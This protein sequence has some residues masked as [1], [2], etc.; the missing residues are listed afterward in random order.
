[1]K[2]KLKPLAEEAASALLTTMIFIVVLALSIGGYMSYVFQ[3]ARLGG[4]S[5]AW[6]MSMAVAEA[7]LEEGFEHLN[8][9]YYIM[10][11][12]GWQSDGG[13]VYHVTRTLNGTFEATYTVTINYANTAQPTIS[14]SAYVKPPAVAQNTTRSPFFY[15]T[16]G[17]NQTPV[18][19][20]NSVTVGRGIQAVLDKPSFFNA[21]MVAKGN[22]TMDGNGVTVDSFDSGTSGQNVNGQWNQSISGND[23]IVA[24]DGGISNSIS[25]GNA[26]IY[27][28]LYV[29][30]GEPYSIG[31]NGF[32][33]THQWVAGGGTGVEPGYAHTD[34]NFD[35]PNTS[36]PNGY[37]NFTPPSSGTIATVTG[38]NII[39]ST[40]ANVASY[41]TGLTNGQ[42]L[43]A[44]LTNTTMITV[45]NGY[46]GAIPGLTSNSAF[47]TVS[48]YPGVE[49]GLV[50]NCANT[51]TTTTDPGSQP[52]LVITS[53]ITNVTTLPSPPP[54]NVTTNYKGSGHSKQISSYSYTVT[55]YSYANQ[56]T[57]T[58]KSWEYTY[59][60]NTYTYTLYSSQIT[61]A[62]SN[63]AAVLS[64]GYYVA[65]SE[66][67]GT[68]I[69]TGP[70]TL[71]MPNGYNIDNLVIAPGGS[72]VVYSGGTSLTLSGQGIIN[73]PG[74]AQNLMIYC[75]PSV[76]SIAFSGNAGLNA[77]IV[78]PNANVTLS[79]GGNNN[80]DFSGSIMANSVTLHGHWNF[81][82]D[83]ALSRVPSPGRYIL[84]SWTEV[85][86]PQRSSLPSTSE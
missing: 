86:V 34:A 18:A 20:S 32:V 58:Y 63:Y 51:V 43:S 57:Y 50:T 25:G 5:Q 52:C 85:T 15:A 1:M 75:T 45:S 40:N 48:S 31:P 4:R 6:N 41:P 3:Q 23:G 67:T 26:N 56:F 69:V 8:D 79:G 59:P 9:D 81:H 62:T 19:N 78:A 24:S 36:L 27:G 71:V 37:Q 10:G 13:G 35:F 28:Q 66:M 33:G 83:V 76:T 2:L 39:A 82:Y 12:D 47:V 42:T 74:L 61:Y 55:D 44:V 80:T 68:T 29:G 17:A 46:P 73:Q 16:I 7:G 54:S 77:V 14:S 30:A 70:V 22:I 65:N 11:N 72:V 38:T 49:P 60:T 64:S 21:A 84:S 53:Y